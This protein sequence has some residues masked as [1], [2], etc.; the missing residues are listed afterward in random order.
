LPPALARR[1][2]HTLGLDSPLPA[3]H[4]LTHEDAR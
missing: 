1:E 3:S 2:H 4:S